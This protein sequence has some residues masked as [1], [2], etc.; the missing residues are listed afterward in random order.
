M[1]VYSLSCDLKL[2]K[3][4]FSPIEHQK[5]CK[6]QICFFTMEMHVLINLVYQNQT[7]VGF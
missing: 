5:L 2:T 7:W 4:T 3:L 1:I 6:C